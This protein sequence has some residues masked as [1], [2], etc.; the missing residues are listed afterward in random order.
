MTAIDCYH[1]VNLST[2]ENTQNKLRSDLFRDGFLVLNKITEYDDI[3][4]IRSEILEIFTRTNAEKKH[5]RDLGDDSTVRGQGQILEIVS[6]SVLKPHLLFSAFFQRAL[7]ISQE[8]LGPSA[9]LL[10]DH[11]IIKPPFNDTATT[12]HQDCAYARPITLSARRLHWWL[13]LQEATR[14]NGCMEFVPGSHLGKVLAHH[15]RAARAH[16]LQTQLPANAVPVACPLPMGG[17]TV[18]LPKT[19]H[20]TGPNNSPAPRLAWIVQIGIKGWKPAIMR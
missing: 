7:C 10:F 2:G 17:A 13:P 19:L 12:W 11:C 4:N 20:Y 8:I 1:Q 15:P 18:H 6:P 9:R 16:A 3:Q 5:I 14:E